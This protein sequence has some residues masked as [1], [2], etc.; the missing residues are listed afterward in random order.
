MDIEKVV[1]S[2]SQLLHGFPG[3]P[4]APLILI[5]ILGLIRV[6][7]LGLSFARRA[8]RKLKVYVNFDKSLHY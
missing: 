7:V 8:V 1:R 3:S 4:I 5:L 2:G 6:L